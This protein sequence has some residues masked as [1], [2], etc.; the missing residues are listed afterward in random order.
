MKMKGFVGCFF[1]GSLA[2]VHVAIELEFELVFMGFGGVGCGL[3]H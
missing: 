3:S 1:S 2:Y